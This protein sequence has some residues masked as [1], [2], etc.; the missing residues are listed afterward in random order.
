M[1][2]A[3]FAS[4]A[5]ICRTFGVKRTTLYDAPPSDET[6]VQQATPVP[7]VLA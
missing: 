6:D 2:T 7:W 5:A 1:I 3:C 4:K